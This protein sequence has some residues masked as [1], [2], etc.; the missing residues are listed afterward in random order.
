MDLTEPKMIIL[1][2]L[3]DQFLFMAISRISEISLT[4]YYYIPEERHVKLLDLS[5]EES[6]RKIVSEKPKYG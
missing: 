4:R 3:K 5:I 1:N 6:I 2:N